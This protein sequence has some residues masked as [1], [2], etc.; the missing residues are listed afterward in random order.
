MRQLLICFRIHEWV[1]PF[2]LYI[3]EFKYVMNRNTTE[4]KN[5]LHSIFSILI[6]CFSFCCVLFRFIR[7]SATISTLVHAKTAKICLILFVFYAKSTMCWCSTI[8]LYI[9]SLNVNSFKLVIHAQL[10]TFVSWKLDI[11]FRCIQGQ[12]DNTINS[13]QK[14]KTRLLLVVHFLLIF[15]FVC[16]WF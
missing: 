2:W 7:P 1:K 6:L 13:M 8:I 14:S 5:W 15:L 10:M 12:N 9:K 16:F 4:D 11:L 3:F